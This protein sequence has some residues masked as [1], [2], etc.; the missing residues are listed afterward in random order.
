MSY[1]CKFGGL[2]HSNMDSIISDG[3]VPTFPVEGC[4]IDTAG[5]TKVYHT[6][7]NFRKLREANKASLTA[8]FNDLITDGGG[9]KH[10]KIACLLGY[11][12]NNIKEAN[13]M[14]N[15]NTSTLERKRALL[16]TQ[17]NDLQKQENSIRSNENSGLVTD[18]RNEETEKVTKKLNTYFILY[19]TF[20]VVFLVVEGILFFV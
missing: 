11:M 18:Y 17:K 5:E 10:A 14:F 13:T 3:I 12:L 19:V 15:T 4:E 16:Q 6:N 1:S 2:T 7:T 8:K 20:I 9:D